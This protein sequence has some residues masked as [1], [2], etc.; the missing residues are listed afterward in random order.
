MEEEFGK[1]VRRPVIREDF[2]EE[3]EF[4]QFLMEEYGLSQKELDDDLEIIGKG[5]RFIKEQ[6]DIVHPVTGTITLYAQED[7]ENYVLE[8]LDEQSYS[9]VDN[10]WR[11]GDNREAIASLIRYPGGQHEWLMVAALPFLKRMGIPLVWMREFRTKTEEC[12]FYYQ[13]GKGQHGGPGSNRMHRDLLA[14]FKSVC[15]LGDC[16]TGTNARCQVAAN[17]EAFAEEHFDDDEIPVPDALRALIQALY[18]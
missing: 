11:D 14:C 12:T 7:K 9:D 4:E 10:I 15:E 8:Y 1:R 13:E 6:A 5:G 2:L 3:K 18:E 16:E 17:L